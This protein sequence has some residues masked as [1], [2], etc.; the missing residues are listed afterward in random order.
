[1]VWDSGVEQEN[2]CRVDNLGFVVGEES[3]SALGTELDDVS[4]PPLQAGA[5]MGLTYGQWN[6]SGSDLFHLWATFLKGSCLLSTTLSPCADW[7]MD[8]GMEMGASLM[9]PARTAP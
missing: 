4:Q 7:T 8:R 5:A 9:M 1:M 3:R 2:R 6:V